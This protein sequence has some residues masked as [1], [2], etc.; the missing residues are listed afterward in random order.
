[1][2]LFTLPAHGSTGTSCRSAA[3]DGAAGGGDATSSA[4]PRYCPIGVLACFTLLMAGHGRCVHASMMLGDHE[5]A[6]WQLAWAQGAGDGE[7]RSVAARLRAYFV[8]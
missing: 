5:Y 6:L 3:T 8:P 4:S 7:L 1:M 2:G